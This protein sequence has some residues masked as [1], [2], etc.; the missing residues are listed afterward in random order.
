MALCPQTT[1]T[2]R[3]VGL[4]AV[5]TVRTA[6]RGGEW[7]AQGFQMTV[8]DLRIH[9]CT[10]ELV[11]DRCPGAR[12]DMFLQMDASVS[13]AVRLAD[14]AAESQPLVWWA[15]L[16]RLMNTVWMKRSMNLFRKLHTLRCPRQGIEPERGLGR[17]GRADRVLRAHSATVGGH[18][19][20]LA[21]QVM[22]KG[23][24]ME[25]MTA[26]TT[27]ETGVIMPVVLPL[28]VMLV[29]KKTRSPLRTWMP[30]A[31]RP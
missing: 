13:A 16:L 31:W 2:W 27:L 28:M 26:S 19:H 12:S 1:S 10:D 20:R 21:Q 5:A 30:R 8:T 4:S 11:T 23:P 6:T 7:W 24:A 17:R 29:F 18:H 22:A 3:L 15:M 9:Y 14:V 25:T